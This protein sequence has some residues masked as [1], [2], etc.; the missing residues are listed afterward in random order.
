M[1]LF[2]TRQKKI[3]MQLF[4]CLASLC[5][6]FKQPTIQVTR[7]TCMDF[8]FQGNMTCHEI[9]PNHKTIKSG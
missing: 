1:F 9:M 2:D 6:T 5:E 4:D 3:E 8:K 7:I